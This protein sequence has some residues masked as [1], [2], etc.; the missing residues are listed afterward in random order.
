MNS[1]NN[2]SEIRVSNINLWAHVGV[3]ED[4][5]KY[6]QNFLL[7]LSLWFDLEDSSINDD[8][9]KSIDYSLSV[10]AIQKLSFNIT[11]LTIE[12][13]SKCILDLLEEIYGQIPMRISLSKCSPPIKGFI[14]SV[15]IEKT[16]YFSIVKNP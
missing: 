10:K 3:L 13:F 2:L 15:S 16:R 1:V 14:G 8:L 9:S 11:C 6:G 5:R 4:E 7:N 12:Y